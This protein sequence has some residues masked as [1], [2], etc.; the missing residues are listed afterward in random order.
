MSQPEQSSQSAARGPIKI[1]VGT[2]LASKLGKRASLVPRFLVHSLE[3]LICQDR[4]NDLLQYGWPRRGADFCRAVVGRLDITTEI[5]NAG[6][7]PTGE[8]SRVIFVSNHPLGGLDG[9]I[10][11]DIVTRLTG[12]EPFFVVNDL[13]MAV[14]PLT[15]VFVPINKHGAQ[16]KAASAALDEAMASDRPVI[17]FPAGL[18]SRRNGGVIADPEWKKMFVQKARRYGRDIVPLHFAGTNSPRFYRTA[19]MRKR[20]H[21]PFN[22]EMLLLPSEVVRNSGA[23][24]TVTV[25]E[26]IPASSLAPDPRAE[27]LR[28]RDIVYSM[29]PSDSTRQFPTE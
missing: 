2:V 1:D 15:D 11:I 9:M 26:R 14:E 16:S 25:G 19:S 29:E 10:L 7:M 6:L 3:K 24:F 28:I 8:G 27:T 13:L 17:I 20:L 5:I 23:R 12:R 18:C 22:L 4:L 21:I